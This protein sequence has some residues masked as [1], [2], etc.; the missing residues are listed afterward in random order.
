MLHK[1]YRHTSVFP[2]EPKG[3]WLLQIGDRIYSDSGKVEEFWVYKALI[4]GC[5]LLLLK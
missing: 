2:F 5:C 3:Y 1:L 4:E